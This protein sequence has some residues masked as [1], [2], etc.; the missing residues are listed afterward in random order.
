MSSSN[1]RN[2]RKSTG[3][4]HGETDSDSDYESK[5]ALGNIKKTNLSG[6]L[7]MSR[8]GNNIT[9]EHISCGTNSNGSL[10]SPTE[11]GASEF[12]LISAVEIGDVESIRRLLSTCET[13]V[14][15]N[16]ATGQTALYVAA[17]KGDTEVVTIL[18]GNS[19]I[20]VNKESNSQTPLF[21][22]ARDGHVEV[23]RLLANP[24]VDVNK[25]NECGVTPLSAAEDR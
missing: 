16:N 15:E 25:P 13:D 4:S 1:S 2:K 22:A 11:S 18:I 21:A 6:Q 14:N 3:G 19:N 9:D 8:S 17:A 10:S 5:S 7:A 20:D 23:V 24:Q 12:R